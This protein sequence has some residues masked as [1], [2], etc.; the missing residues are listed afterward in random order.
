MS[1]E[2]YTHLLDPFGEADSCRM[3]KVAA[4]CGGVGAAR[5]LAGLI[6]VMDPKDLTG[7]VNVGDDT[8]LH[9][10][11]ISPDLDTITYTLAGLNDTD[12]G[13]GL[14]DETWHAME[15][16]HKVAARR[17]EGSSA[18]STWFNLGDRDL[19]TH[20]YRTGRLAEGAPLSVITCELTAALGVASRLLPAT[21]DP[22][23]T[24]LTLGPLASGTATGEG[25]ASVEAATPG[26]EVAFQEWFV[27]MRHSEPV[28]KVRFD[29]AATARP[30]P[31]VVEAIYSAAAVVICPSNPIVSLDPV[32]AVG[33]VAGAVR[34]RRASAVAVS[35][36][37]AG[38]AL[39]GPADRLMED[40]GH[41]VSAV[42]VARLLAPWAATLIIDEA[43]A[44]LASAV[45]NEGMA[46]VVAPTVMSDPAAAA[47]LAR[48]VLGV[49]G[50]S[51]N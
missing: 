2:T 7:I 4:I 11:S 14:Q 43:D 20:L 13:W 12:R 22:L 15:A 23:S 9:G 17:P 51:G 38:A 18:G 26:R 16:L 19:A 34:D 36:I 5:L 39:K 6:Q 29:G 27:G 47:A 3:R 25:P 42:G 33:A 21:D 48:V 37:V 46:C 45:E 35:P 10:L 41:E 49:S 1:L 24:K 30:A 8:T 40:L 32:L 44:A 50:V 28:A 31:G